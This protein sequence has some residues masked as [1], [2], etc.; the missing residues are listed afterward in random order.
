MTRGELKKTRR[1]LMRRERTYIS[2]EQSGPVTV[3]RD[4]SNKYLPVRRRLSDGP[5]KDHQAGCL[6]QRLGRG[7][8]LLQLNSRKPTKA[9]L[10]ML[11][12]SHLQINNARKQKVGRGRQSLALKMV[13]MVRHASSSVAAEQAN[14]DPFDK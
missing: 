4:R 2:T 14:L 10:L 6:W 13:K 1:Y 3:T 7:H 5:G 11:G 8:H 12:V 9:L